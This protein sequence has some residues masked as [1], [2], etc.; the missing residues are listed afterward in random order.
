MAYQSD[1]L[2]FA[3]SNDH[4]ANMPCLKVELRE[5]VRTMIQM[6][7]LGLHEAKPSRPLPAFECRPILVNTAS[8]DEK[9]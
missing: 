4:L 1:W 5:L 3:T 6:R 9:G 2:Y 8:P 7:D